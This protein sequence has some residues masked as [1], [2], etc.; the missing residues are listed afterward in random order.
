MNEHQLSPPSWIE[1]QSVIPLESDKPGVVS[2]RSVTSLSI[3]ALER[4][5]PEFIVRPSR[6]RRGMKLK[7]ALR[8]AGTVIPEASAA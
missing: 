6:G 7:H 3:D 1:L 8:I 2:A 4:E 5:Y